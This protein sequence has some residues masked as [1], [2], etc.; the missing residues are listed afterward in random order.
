VPPA[1]RTQQLV[2]VLLGEPL[3]GWVVARR[4]DGLSWKAITAELTEC[5]NGQ[6]DLNP[7]TLRAWHREVDPKLPLGRTA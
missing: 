4:A 2:E 3:E 5:T 1:T 7:E 6:C